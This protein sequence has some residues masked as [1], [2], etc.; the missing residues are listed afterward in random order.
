MTDTTLAR[1]DAVMADYEVLREGADA[2]RCRPYRVD[3]TKRRKSITQDAIRAVQAATEP[4]RRADFI[5]A[6]G[7]S[8]DAELV[9]ASGEC[10]RMTLAERWATC[11]GVGVVP[12]GLFEETLR[13]VVLYPDREPCADGI[14][15]YRASGAP[16][17]PIF[18]A[19]FIEHH[20][21]A[22][23]S[24]THKPTGYGRRAW[25]PHQYQL[26]DLRRLV[27]RDLERLTATDM[28]RGRPR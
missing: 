27:C 28:H 12:G 19:D 24:I 2:M 3:L 7:G 18:D 10:R 25:G 15:R 8:I 17:G 9:Y 16:L 11:R 6:T 23:V 14:L 20:G 1:I 21:P 5:A 26:A 13:E 22:W 4:Q